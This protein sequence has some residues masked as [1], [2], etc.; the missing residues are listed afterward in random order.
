MVK[1][2]AL[3]FATRAR[4]LFGIV[5]LSQFFTAVVTS[6]ETSV[7]AVATGTADATA[8]PKVGALLF[9]MVSSPHAPFTISILNEPA[10]VTLFK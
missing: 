6:T 4:P 10:V 7:F 2:V 8:L 9:V 1:F 3:V 5:P